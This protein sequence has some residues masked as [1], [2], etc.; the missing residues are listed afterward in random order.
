MRKLIIIFLLFVVVVGAE[1]KKYPVTEIQN[2]RLRTKQLEVQIAQQN[3]FI[4]QQNLSNAMKILREEAAAVRNENGW[5]SE[6]QFDIEKLIFVDP[7]KSPDRVKQA[8][9]GIQ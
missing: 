6:V 1:D 2:L 3:V 7:P 8:P 5:A 4:A 9:G